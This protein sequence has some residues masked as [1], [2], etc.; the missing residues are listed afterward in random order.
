MDATNAT[1]TTYTALDG[2]V[3]TYGSPRHFEIVSHCMTLLPQL[4]LRKIMLNTL[5][6]NGLGEFAARLVD[7][8]H[9]TALRY[10]PIAD[11]QRKCAQ[12]GGVYHAR[13]GRGGSL[14]DDRDRE[15][16]PYDEVTST[17]VREANSHWFHGAHCSDECYEAAYYEPPTPGYNW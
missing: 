9:A 3:V 10:G 14:A 13:S 11:S 6:E 12:C 2:E 16:F 1:A 15:L 7:V 5:R 4:H 17:G 8:D